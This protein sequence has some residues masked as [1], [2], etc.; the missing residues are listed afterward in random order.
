MQVSIKTEDFKK[1][2]EKVWTQMANEQM[3]PAV[4]YGTAKIK[5]RKALRED[6]KIE[7]S[8][9]TVDKWLKSCYN[10]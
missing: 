7:V 1:V 10:F 2:C 3:I 8:K 5:V 4:N 9:E 6:L